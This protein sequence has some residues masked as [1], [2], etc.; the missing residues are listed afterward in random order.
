MALIPI[1]QE[2]IE[3][4]EF[5][6]ISPYKTDASGAALIVTESVS[7]DMLSE[8]AGENVPVLIGETKKGVQKIL[9]RGSEIRF[10][11]RPKKEK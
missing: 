1:P 8:F 5:A 7:F 4:C 6:G 9:R 2:V 3:V 10:L 11:E